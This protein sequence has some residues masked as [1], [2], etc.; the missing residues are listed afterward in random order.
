VAECL[1]YAASRGRKIAWE[2]HETDAAALVHARQLSDRRLIDLML[3][4][5]GTGP[6]C[7]PEGATS[8]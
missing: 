7:R 8:R 4:G 6:E 1:R 5:S 3:C 2:L